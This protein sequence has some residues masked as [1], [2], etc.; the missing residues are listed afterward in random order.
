MG[1]SKASKAQAV[2]KESPEIKSAVE[3]QP[4]ASSSD[5]SSSASVHADSDSGSSSS[6]EDS[7][8]DSDA[9]APASSL[10]VSKKDKSSTSKKRKRAVVNEPL[11]DLEDPD[12]PALS[13]AE[14]RKQ[15]KKPS[16]VEGI[17]SSSTSAAKKPGKVTK[18]EDEPHARGNRQNS[19]WVGNLSF[20][21]T[22]AQLREFFA[23]AGEVTRV[24]L[25]LKPV[26]ADEPATK[27]KSTRDN[28]GYVL[29]ICKLLACDG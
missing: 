17:A 9:E 5:A 7:D 23:P 15:K 18:P 14:K 24:N 16:A 26:V 22:E 1:K 6:S 10:P 13:H 8:N 25:P 12:A 20:R 11:P 3:D 27:W 29:Y 19:I 2:V 21:T 4:M 28:R